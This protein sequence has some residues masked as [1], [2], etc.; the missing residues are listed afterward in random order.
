VDFGSGS[1]GLVVQILQEIRHHETDLN[2]TLSRVA[3]LHKEMHAQNVE[4]EK[5]KKVVA[6]LY[7]SL[8]NSESDKANV[9]IEYEELLAK[10]E[11]QPPQKMTMSD[12]KNMQKDSPAQARWKQIRDNM[13][14]VDWGEKE[15]E[16]NGGGGASRANLSARAERKRELRRQK[17]GEDPKPNLEP[18]PEEGSPET[19]RTPTNTTPTSNPTDPGDQKPK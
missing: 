12:L 5:K 16:L 17:T 18:E 2:S 1:K 9:Q 15:K 11:P 4:I 13:K 14:K 6:E 19:P 7:E 8:K 3:G 10:P